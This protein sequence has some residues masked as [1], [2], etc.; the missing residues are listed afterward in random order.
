MIQILIDENLPESLAEGLNAL[1]KPLQ[2]DIEIV[3]LVTEF[4]KGTKD[5][6]WIPKW[7]KKAG[8]FLTQDY[9]IAK[10]RHQAQ[11]LKKHNMGALFLRVQAKAKY[12][13]RV[14]ILIKFWP[15]IVAHIKKAK[16][17]YCYLISARKIE[18]MSL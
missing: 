11:L 16:R 12:W 13:D 6:D 3:H 1:N 2:N 4:G 9:N 7:G 5:E 8:I 15:E 18:I 10:T 14:S 17:P